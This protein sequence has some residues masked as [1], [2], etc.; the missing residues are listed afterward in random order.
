MT[1]N[2]ITLAK[3]RAWKKKYY[4]RHR[5]YNKN[6]YTRWTDA[7]CLRVLLHDIPDVQLSKEIGRSLAAI[8][9]KRTRLMYKE[10]GIAV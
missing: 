6:N 2:P 10:G 3:R 4:T 5:K 7:E 1:K 8:H 9:E